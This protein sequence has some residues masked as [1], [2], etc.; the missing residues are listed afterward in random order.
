MAAVDLVEQVT[1]HQQDDFGELMEMERLY[2]SAFKRKP[3]LCR[4]GKLFIA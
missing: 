4:C 2:L 1:F 3:S